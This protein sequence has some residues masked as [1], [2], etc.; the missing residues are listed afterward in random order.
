M[1]DTARTTGIEG[2][3]VNL[4]SIAHLHTCEDGIQFDKINDKDRYSHGRCNVSCEYRCSKW[5]IYVLDFVIGAFSYSDKRAYGQSKLANIL[6][7]KELSRRLQV[8]FPTQICFWSAKS[9]LVNWFYGTEYSDFGLC[10]S[11]L[12]SLSK[13]LFLV[14]SIPRKQN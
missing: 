5:L 14:F 7:A 10:C 12:I 6:H 9:F 3:I 11:F 4:S 1:K 8:I 2:R 13:F